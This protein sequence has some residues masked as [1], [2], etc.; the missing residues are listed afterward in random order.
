MQHDSN[1]NFFKSHITCECKLPNRHCKYIIEDF[2]SIV[3]S[4]RSGKF[5][6]I[7]FHI[8]DNKYI[9]KCMETIKHRFFFTKVNNSLYVMSKTSVAYSYLFFISL[10]I[11][12]NDYEKCVNMS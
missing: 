1:V 11:E 9:F 3:C 4:Q 2:S 5:T 8:F 10:K 12:G 6:V 7:F